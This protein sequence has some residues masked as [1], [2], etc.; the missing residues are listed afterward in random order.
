MIRHPA[1]RRIDPW[2]IREDKLDLSVLSQTE[3]IFALSNGHIGLRGNLDEGEPYGVPGTYLNGVYDLR[4][5]KQAESGFGYPE[6]ADTVVNVTNGKVVRLLVNDEPFDVRYGELRSHERSLDLRAGTLAREAVWTSPAGA[7]VRIRST[8]LVSLQQR[9]IAAIRYDVTPINVPVRAV[10]LSE[11]VTN[12]ALPPPGPD[13]RSSPLEQLPLRSELVAHRGSRVV[14]VHSTGRSGLRVAAAMDHVLRGPR[15][16][17]SETEADPDLGRV[18]VTA[19]LGRN[20]TLTLVKFLA[21]GWSS[22]RSV[23]ALRDQVEGALAEAVRTGWDGLVTQQRTALNDFWYRA[24]IDLEGDEAV[25][26]A[27]H[28]GLFHTFQAAVR[29]EDRPIPAKGLTG[30]GYEG[31]TFWDMETFVLH[32][33]TYLAPALVPSGLRWRRKSLDLARERAAVLGLRGAA[34]PW[35]TIRGHECSGYWPAGTAAFH[36]NADIADA[37]ARYCEAVDDPE[38]EA[39]VGLELLVETARLWASLGCYDPAGKFRIDGVTGP[40][41]YGAL[42]DNNV[43]TNLM[44]Q[45]NLR[46]AAAMVARY[47]SRARTFRVTRAEVAEWRRAADSMTIPFDAA[48]RVHPQSETSIEHERWDFESTTPE[49]YPLFLHFPYFHLYRKQVVKQADLVLALHLR[50][51]AFTPEQKRR[52]FD[53]YEGLTVR[54][55]SLSACTQA[56]V[57]AEVGHTD[58]AYDYLG[59]SA[60]IDIDDFESTVRDGVH[61]AALAGCWLAAVAGLGGMRVRD[62][63]IRFAPRLPSGISRLAFRLTFRGSLLAVEIDRH[64]A[65]YRVLLGPSISVA[66]HGRPVKIGRRPVSVAIPRA[67]PLPPPKQ[68]KGRAPEHRRDLLRHPGRRPPR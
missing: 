67:V 65:R 9:A 66:H 19:D 59:E 25:E 46:V 23:P 44:A 5:M 8:R 4:P 11:L 56:I 58:L 33:L 2:V 45:H 22:A 30:P 36:I 64:R 28:F 10:L 26:Q 35:R 63:G 51:D 32:A 48:R 12:E 49:Q 7:T 38:F 60:L 14:L 15:G 40:N 20:R 47:R 13:P 52:A 3:S 39:G 53:Y 16:I 27:L 34:F 57:A 50:G 42:S 54:D 68:P 43:Y 61:I 18:T 24:A 17:A 31:H 21:Y 1:F 37:V 29:A 55:S 6:T 41:E 62:G